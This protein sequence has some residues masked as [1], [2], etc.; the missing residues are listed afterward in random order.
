MELRGQG[1]YP[2]EENHHDCSHGNPGRGGHHALLK[3]GDGAL[4]VCAGGI[5]MQ[6]SMQFRAHRQNRQEQNQRDSARRKEAVQERNGGGW[7]KS[8]S[9]H[10]TIDHNG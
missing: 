5:A 8:R 1:R 7:R 3:E 6:P 2:V 10:L 4:M 9:L